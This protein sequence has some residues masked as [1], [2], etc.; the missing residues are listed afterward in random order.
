MTALKAAGIIVEYNPFH[1]GHVYHVNQAK[2]KTN[3]E[4]IV[5][6]MSGDFLQRGEPAFIDKW[7][8]SKMALQNGVDLIFELP[9]AF[10]T[11]HA[12]VFADGAIQLLDAARCQSFCF[13]SE[14]GDIKPLENSI[15]LIEQAG[16]AYELAVKDAVSR[17]LSYPKALNE[18]YYASSSN[19]NANQNVADLSKPN[20]IL[21]FHYMLAAKKQKSNMQAVTI[22]RVVANYYDDAIS[23]NTIASATGIRKSYFESNNILSVKNFIPSKTADEL[24]Q[25]VM[26]RQTFG[27]WSTFYPHLRFTILR[28]RPAR[29]T[30]IAD[31]TEG[32]ENLIYRAAQKHDTFEGFMKE[33]KSKRYTWTRIQRMLTHIFTGFTYEQRELIEAP[34]YLRLLGMTKTGQRYL[35]QIKKELSLPLVSKVSKFSDLSLQIDM[36]AAN[37]YALGVSNEKNKASIGTDYKTAPIMM[38]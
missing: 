17:G 29:L 23:G 24:Q 35:N 20:N 36:H 6:V 37:M 26:H 7:A 22:P 12:P 28:E 2:A 19:D 32:I 31:I 15:A 8:R 11:A 18:A 38:P 9:Y 33:V 3:A 27:H 5:A 21:G 25:W 34:T 16:D 1:N 30:Q 4:V 13:G 14:E 10:A